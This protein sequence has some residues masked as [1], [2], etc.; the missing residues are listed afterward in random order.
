[1]SKFLL[2]LLLI[3]PHFTMRAQ[4]TTEA[5]KSALDCLNNI[6][7]F[8]SID[9]QYIISVIDEMDA[10]VAKQDIAAFDKLTDQVD[11]LLIRCGLIQD[12]HL[13]LEKMRDCMLASYNPVQ[14]ADTSTAFHQLLLHLN[15]L[16]ENPSLF[17][18]LSPLLHIEALYSIIPDSLLQR[19]FYRVYPFIFVQGLVHEMKNVSISEQSTDEP[20]MIVEE[21][22]EAPDGVQIEMMNDE[23]QVEIVDDEIPVDSINDVQIKYDPEI[24]DQEVFTIV[25]KNP[26]FPG[27]DEA[28]KA[29]TTMKSDCGKGKAYVS[30]T[31]DCMGNVTEP[32][33][34]RGLNSDCDKK[35]IERV[36]SMPAWEPGSQRGEPRNVMVNLEFTFI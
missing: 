33:I 9:N 13:N 18:E 35:A 27:G 17:Y 3:L 29:F 23:V 7:S 34:L 4:N 30:I 19:E 24:C 5:E 36:Q 25:E 14:S 2:L 8:A 16:A 12:E 1:M 22:D 10:L 6:L 11:S 32:K 31:V 15:S 28:L 20:I 26:V 21:V